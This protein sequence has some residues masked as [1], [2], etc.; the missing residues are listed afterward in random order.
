MEWLGRND[1]NGDGKQIK[2]DY[3]RRAEGDKRSIP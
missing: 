2:N 1:G 3:G